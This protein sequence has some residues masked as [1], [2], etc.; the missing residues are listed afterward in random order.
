M[1]ESNVVKLRNDDEV[2]VATCMNC[3]NRAWVLHIDKP[4]KDFSMIT[5]LQCAN[6][7]CGMFIN[8]DLK[9]TFG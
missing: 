5:K 6:P 4:G 3:H 1:P 2:I 7:D 9:L 8:V